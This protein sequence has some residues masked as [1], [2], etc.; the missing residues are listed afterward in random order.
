[1]ATQQ[2][3]PEQ[4]INPASLLHWSIDALPASPDAFDYEFGATSSSLPSGWSWD[5][6]GSSTYSEADGGGTIQAPSSGATSQR[7]IVKAIPSG[8]TWT[9][10]GKF[11]MQGSPSGV[12]NAGMLLRN[13]VN[14]K[15]AQFG[16][17]GSTAM[18]ALMFTNPTTFS[19]SISGD[20]NV[21]GTMGIHYLRVK[22]NSATSYDFAWSS[23]GS[24]WKDC[25]LAYDVAALTGTLDQIGFT[26]GPENSDT[27]GITCYWMRKTA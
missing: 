6:Q 8:T 7:S 15:I 4:Q 5:N 20:I 9:V 16:Y 24:V 13:S 3:R 23:N 27:A 2:I 17:R 21:M 1:M 11:L 14:S 19:T 12:I 10:I 26:V 22:K 25:A 18:R